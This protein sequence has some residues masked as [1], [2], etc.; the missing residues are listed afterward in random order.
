MRKCVTTWN[1]T[2]GAA[3]SQQIAKAFALVG[4]VGRD[5]EDVS[6]Q[7]PSTVTPERLAAIPLD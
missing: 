7:R 2:P 1:M 5:R 3:V 4:H 6:Y